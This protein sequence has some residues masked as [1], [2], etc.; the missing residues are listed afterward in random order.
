MKLRV[1]LDTSIFS[2]VLDHRVPERQRQTE[3]FFQRIAEFE[4]STS[5]LT[6]LEMRQTGDSQLQLRMLQMLEGIARVT[7]DDEMRQLAES[8]VASGVFTRNM[9]ADAL[10]VAA[11]VIS[12]QDVLLSWN[13]RH[14]VNRRR[15]GRV[16]DINA[17]QGLPRI[18]ILAPSE[19]LYE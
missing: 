3:D 4:V 7:I 14:L 12:R 8:Y 9:E 18:E 1:Y 17:V 19:V 16:N 13:F 11:A 10:H 2:A 6:E 5:E 15:R